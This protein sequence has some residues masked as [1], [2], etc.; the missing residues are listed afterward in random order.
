MDWNDINHDPLP[1]AAA[2]FFGVGVILA[3]VVL[4]VATFGNS[5]NQEAFKCFRSRQR[6]PQ[7]SKV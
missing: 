2:I 5:S 1:R 7:N 3:I 6:A 4:A